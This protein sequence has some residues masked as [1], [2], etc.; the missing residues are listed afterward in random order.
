MTEEQKQILHDA[1]WYCDEEDKS[2]EFM[3]QYMSDVS[4]I[5]YGIVVDFVCH[6][7]LNERLKFRNMPPQPQKEFDE[8]LTG[9]DKLVGLWADVE[10]DGVVERVKIMQYKR[11]RNRQNNVYLVSYID[12]KGY[13]KF[14][15]MSNLTPHKDVNKKLG[16]EN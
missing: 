6:T 8:P 13:V 12:C 4:G 7:S 9:G 5:D 2:T 1:W 11:K 14:N 10:R 3:F 15:Q 16:D